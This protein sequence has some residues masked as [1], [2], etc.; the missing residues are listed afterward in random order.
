MIIAFILLLHTATP[1]QLTCNSTDRAWTRQPRLYI[2]SREVLAPTA[3]AFSLI[4]D[5]TDE[6]VSRSILETGTWQP[7]L[8]TLISSLLRAGDRV[9]NLGCQTGFEAVVMGKIIG[10]KG[11]MFLFEP[12]SV[13]YKMAVKNIYLNGLEAVSRVY[14]I[15]AGEGKSQMKLWI[16]GANTGHSSLVEEQGL[17]KPYEVIEVDRVDSIVQQGID[18]AL[19][20]V[21]M[22][23]V[24]ALLG[25]K[26]ILGKSPSIIVLLEWRYLGN[27]G[28]EEGKARELLDWLADRHFRW[29]HYLPDSEA[30][31]LGTI[32]PI[33]P[34]EMLGI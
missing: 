34:Q 15:G 12:Y 1:Y 13:S 11:Q 26:G 25:M 4:V 28:R 19:I 5:R 14:K 2:N 18:F 30:C 27:P 32:K 33:S 29:F 20:D 22:F 6:V 16:D 10:E 23:E 9:I 17:Q 24:K 31:R 3:H 7:Q 21:E 8:L